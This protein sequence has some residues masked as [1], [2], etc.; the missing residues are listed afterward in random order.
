MTL[1]AAVLGMAIGD[2]LGVPVEF[3]RRDALKKNP[4]KIMRE[5]GT[6]QQPKG[7]WSDDSTMAFCLLE[8]LAENYDLQNLANHFIN[9]YRHAY[10]TPHGTVFDMGNSTRQAIRRLEEGIEPTQAGGQT[11][12]SNGN[13][14]LMRILPLLFYIKDK[15]LEERWQITQDVSSLTHG[16]FVACFA[17]F[18]YLEYARLLL[19]GLDKFQA[20]TNMQNA[21][22][23]F[24]LQQ[25]FDATH[26]A[27]FDR[28][29]SQSIDKLPETSIKSDGYVLHTLE[30]SLWCLLNYHDYSSTVL[31]SVN[32]GKDTDT[33]ATVT[34]GLAGILYGEEGIPMMWMAYL[35]RLNDILNLIERA[36]KKLN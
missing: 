9:W 5:Y 25:A 17:C 15:P 26:L 29:L 11:F 23:T 12:D 3:M 35:A 21:I 16:H 36:E 2:A 19:E 14:S 33:T 28:V 20:Y 8:T 10:W 1:K 30:A 32:L 6:H 31:A 27:L 34:G 22:N 7:T 18:I 4:V 13:G 24:A